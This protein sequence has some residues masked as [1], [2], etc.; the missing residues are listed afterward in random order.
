[1]PLMMGIP[2]DRMVSV[3]ARGA[4]ALGYNFLGN[5]RLATH[6]A[7]LFKQRLLRVFFG[8]DIPIRMPQQLLRAPAINAVADPD[9]SA[10]ALRMLDEHV[11]ASGVA[12]FNH[13]AAVLGSSR[14]GVAEKLADI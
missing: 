11:Q 13:P 7:P 12:C 4:D 14:D 2:D 8:P 6:L 5:S 10:I 3:F 9:L 1:M